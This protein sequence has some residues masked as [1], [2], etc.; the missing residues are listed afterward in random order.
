MA[1]ELFYFNYFYLSA[2]SQSACV[3]PSLPDVN[4]SADGYRMLAAK[5]NYPKGL[6]WIKNREGRNNE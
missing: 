6:N 4:N 3:Q 5:K 1:H 2:Y